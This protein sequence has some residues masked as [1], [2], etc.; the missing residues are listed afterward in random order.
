LSGPSTEA[1]GER[2]LSAVS[3]ELSDAVRMVAAVLVLGPLTYIVT[4]AVRA[5]RRG[6][7][8]GK[9]ALSTVRLVGPPAILAMVGL[10]GLMVLAAFSFVALILAS[11]RRW[12][13]TSRRE[14]S[15]LSSLEG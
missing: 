1:R 13:T 15:S 10:L 9:A 12:G 14:T 4:R 6:E 11:E 5:G 2:V 7:S 8:A 3:I